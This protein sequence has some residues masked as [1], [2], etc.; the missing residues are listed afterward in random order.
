MAAYGW[1]DYTPEMADEEILARLLALNLERAGQSG[2]KKTRRWAG[3]VE[4]GRSRSGPQGLHG[5]LG[6]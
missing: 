3:A 5:R 4:R 6:V 2:A 1:D